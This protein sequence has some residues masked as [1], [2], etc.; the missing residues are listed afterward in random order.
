MINLIE[1]EIK[2][3]NESPCKGLFWR[4]RVSTFI[5]THNGIISRRDLYFLKSKSCPG[6]PACGWVFEYLKEDCSLDNTQF[7]EMLNS[8]EH[9]KLYT[10]EVVGG[11][12]WETGVYELDYIDI[13]EV[14]DKKDKENE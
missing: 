1:K 9:G 6:C 14:K 2:S 5:S 4:G 12:D 11:Y 7:T 13:V 10:Y 8:I 3:S